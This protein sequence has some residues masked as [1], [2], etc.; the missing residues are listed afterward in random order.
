MYLKWCKLI[1]VNTL[2]FFVPFALV[3]HNLPVCVWFLCFIFLISNIH[4]SVLF[5]SVSRQVP[6]LGIL[7]DPSSVCFSDFRGSDFLYVSVSLCLI[8]PFSVVLPLFYRYFCYHFPLLAGAL[9]YFCVF[10]GSKFNS[11]VLFNYTPT[12]GQAVPRTT[13]L[14]PR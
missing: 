14:P 7:S 2:F 9:T 6:K 1:S 10:L 4:H 5:L 8:V 3:S 12:E 11:V 13:T